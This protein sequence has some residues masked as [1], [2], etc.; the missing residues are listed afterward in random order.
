M[1]CCPRG[2]ST[3]KFSS[4]ISPQSQQQKEMGWEAMTGQ[5]VKVNTLLLSFLH[6][7]PHLFHDLLLPFLLFAFNFAQQRPILGISQFQQN[8]QR[9]QMD[10]EVMLDKFYED[11]FFLLECSGP[12][13]M[14]RLSFF[15]YDYK[16]STMLKIPLTTAR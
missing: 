3:Q 4:S 7:S 11:H 6:F 10:C 15:Y 2:S 16:N 12:V 9:K 1:W 5:L 8:Q 14:S 13:C